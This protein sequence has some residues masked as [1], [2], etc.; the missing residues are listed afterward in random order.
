MSIYIYGTGLA[1]M[2]CLIAWAFI[3]DARADREE[4]EA[5]FQTTISCSADAL[6]N[7]L[8]AL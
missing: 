6:E 3:Q 8:P 4:Q 2:V 1:L 7:D 5:D